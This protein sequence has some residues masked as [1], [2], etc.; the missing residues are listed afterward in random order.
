MI[1]ALFVDADGAYSN[2]P[3]VD[4]WDMRRNALNYHGFSPVIAHP[5]C[6]VWCQLAPLNQAR[7]GRKIGEDGGCF[8]HALESVRRFGGV[9]EHPA[10]SIA[11]NAFGLLRPIAG[12]WQRALDGS[13]VCEVNQRA[14]GHPA[15]K[16]TWLYACVGRPPALRWDDPAPEATVSFLTNHGGGSLRRLSKKEARAT[17]PAFRDA[18]IQIAQS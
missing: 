13:W 8:R 1:A 17:S 14:Y 10:K 18:L 16:A 6:S 2:H 5:P 11:W 4:A 12:G 3:D 7:Y 9:L 15:R